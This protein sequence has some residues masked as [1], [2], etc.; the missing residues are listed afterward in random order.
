MRSLL[1]LV[2]IPLALAGCSHGDSNQP[3]A[4]SK[5]SPPGHENEILAALRDSFRLVNPKLAYVRLLDLRS[6]YFEGSRV[7]LAWSIVKDQVFRGDFNDEMFGVFV[8]NDSLTR[9]E[10]VV[11]TIPTPRWM[12]FDMRLGRVTWDSVDVIGRGM[13]YGDGA[14]TRHYRWAPTPRAER[15]HRDYPADSL[16]EAVGDFE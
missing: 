9:I 6:W 16:P 13:T 10:R 2:A 4:V 3:N 11:A 1:A 7:V 14:I 8:V 15:R 12:D 5:S